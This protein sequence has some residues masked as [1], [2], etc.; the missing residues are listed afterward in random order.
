MESTTAKFLKIIHFNDVYNLEEKKSEP[1]VGAARFLT[2]LN[3]QREKGNPL[4]FFS[5]DIFS[6]SQLSPVK[7]GK[8]MYPF[9]EYAKIDWCW[10]GNHDLDF[11]KVV[12]ERLKDAIGVPWLLS[13]V[14]EPGYESQLWGCLDHLIIEHEGIK[15]GLFGL[16]EEEWIDTLIFVG[17]DDYEYEDFIKWAKKWAKALKEEEGCDIVIALTHMR[18]PNDKKLAIKV[19]EID[20]ILGGHD[21]SSQAGN[22]ND[23]FIWK[24]GSDFME[25]S[26]IN[27]TLTQNDELFMNSSPDAIVWSKSKGLIISKK[28]IMITSEFEPFE[29]MR[30]QIEDVFVGLNQKLDRDWGYTGVDLDCTF[31]SI[32]SK[33]TN[34]ANFVADSCRHIIGTDI[35][36]FNSG[37]LRSDAIIKAGVIK[38]RD[39]E[40]LLPFVESFVVLRVTGAELREGLENGVSALPKFEGKFPWISGIRFTYDSRKPPFERVINVWI[41]GEPLNPHKTYSMVTKSFLAQG[42]DGYTCFKDSEVERLAE[43]TIDPKTSLIDYC[44]EMIVR[45]L[46]KDSMSQH[47]LKALEIVHNLELEHTDVD[48][49]G[50]QLR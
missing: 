24:S 50:N 19:P 9:F 20:I 43:D 34:L 1:V 46:M 7:K 21:H 27:I 26:T 16:A 29:P 10:V 41:N 15:V 49:E 42:K 25:L 8:H 33:E 17:P 3:Q 14:Y 36:L 13:N 11:G 32:R 5:G 23:V 12:F 48:D 37:T 44:Q 35:W 45:N 39:I 2:A 31:Q 4:V 22:I 38:F 6:P 47:T 40:N 30:I 18:M 28:K